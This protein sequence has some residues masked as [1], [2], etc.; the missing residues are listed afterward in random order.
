MKRNTRL[1]L[2]SHQKEDIM[3]T[4]IYKKKYHKPT[5]E[6]IKLDNEISLA[7]QSDYNEPGDPGEPGDIG[8]LSTG[9]LNPNPFKTFF[10]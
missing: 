4:K 2:N 5:I 1:T 8:S 9:Y 6:R 10:S 3:N 7:L